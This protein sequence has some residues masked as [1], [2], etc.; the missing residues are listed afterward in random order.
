MENQKNRNS[1]EWLKKLAADESLWVPEAYEIMPAVIAHEYY[2]LHNLAEEGNVYGVILQ[3][4]DVYEAI[5]KY[6]CVLAL[7]ILQYAQTDENKAA[8][9]ALMAEVLKLKLSLGAWKG[10][11]DELKKNAGKLPPAL[12]EIIQ[13]TVKM[14]NQDFIDGSGIIQWRNDTIGHG[15]LRVENDS[16]LKK[17]IRLMVG[18]L[19][20][21][22]GEGG[23]DIA[24]GNRYDSI[25]LKQG[26]KNLVGRGAAKIE[27]NE[28]PFTLEIENR[29]GKKVQKPDSEGLNYILP[30]DG[31]IAFFDTYMQDK[32]KS[33]Y[34][35]YVDG[36]LKLELKGFFFDLYQELERKGMT[37]KAKG[38]SDKATDDQVEKLINELEKT[39][40]FEK[41]E[42]IY[43]W[44]NEKIESCAKGCFMLQMARGM[45]K[46]ALTS[47][48]DG[49]YNNKAEKKYIKGNVIVRTYHCSRNQLRG[50]NDFVMNI[51]SMFLEAD[52]L[53]NHIKDVEGIFKTVP[54]DSPSREAVTEML[55]SCAKELGKKI[56][57]VID[58][59]D[60]IVNHQLFSLFPRQEALAEGVYVFYTARPEHEVPSKALR[61]QIETI[62]LSE[63]AWQILDNNP[64]HQMVVRQYAKKELKNTYGMADDSKEYLTLADKADYNF[65]N[66]RILIPVYSNG[67]AID[68]ETAAD[69]IALFSNYLDFVRGKYGDKFFETRLLPLLAVFGIFPGGLVFKTELAVLL[70]DKVDNPLMLSATLNDL[71]GVLS[72][73]RSDRGNVYALA[74]EEY[75][76]YIRK[77]EPYASWIGKFKEECVAEIRAATKAVRTEYDQ[78]I[79]EISAVY[80]GQGNEQ[81]Y[82]I[83]MYIKKHFPKVFVLREKMLDLLNF[84]KTELRFDHDFSEED[85]KTIFFFMD[86]FPFFAYQGFRMDAGK[87]IEEGKQRP[88]SKELIA[89]GAKMDLSFAE[90]FWS[91]SACMGYTEQEYIRS[92]NVIYAYSKK[93]VTYMLASIKEDSIGDFGE[94]LFYISL[95]LIKTYFWS[96]DRYTEVFMQYGIMLLARNPI[97]DACKMLLTIIHAFKGVNFYKILGIY[98]EKIVEEDKVLTL[99]ECE[100]YLM[101]NEKFIKLIP[102]FDEWDI[103]VEES[104]II[105]DGDNINWDES[106]IKWQKS[107]L[108]SEGRKK[109]VAWKNNLLINYKIQSGADFASIKADYD[110]LIE[111]GGE[112]HYIE[113]EKNGRDERFFADAVQALRE[114]DEWKYLKTKLAEI[115]YS[116]SPAQL[117]KEL[118][119]KTPVAMDRLVEFCADK[120]REWKEYYEKAIEDELPVEYVPHNQIGPILAYMVV[121]YPDKSFRPEEGRYSIEFLDWVRKS[122]ELVEV[123][124][125]FP[126][127]KMEDEEIVRWYEEL[128][129]V[130]KYKIDLLFKYRE[131]TER[132]IVALLEWLAEMNVLNTKVYQRIYFHEFRACYHFLLSHDRERLYKMLD[133]NKLWTKIW[134]HYMGAPRDSSEVSSA[135]DFSTKCIVFS[136]RFAHENPSKA[137]DRKSAKTGD[138]Q[139]VRL[140][141]RYIEHYD[142]AP[143]WFAWIACHQ[144]L[145][146]IGQPAANAYSVFQNMSDL[147]DGQIKKLDADVHTDVVTPFNA[148]RESC[149]TCIVGALALNEINRVPFFVKRLRQMIDKVGELEKDKYLDRGIKDLLKDE[150]IFIK[151]GLE[152][153]HIIYSYLVGNE[154]ANNTAEEMRKAVN[155]ASSYGILFIDVSGAMGLAIL[156]LFLGLCKTLLPKDEFDEML[157]EKPVE[158][159]PVKLPAELKEDILG[160]ASEENVVMPDSNAQALQKQLQ[161]AMQTYPFSFHDGVFW[162]DYDCSIKE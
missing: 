75:V 144:L 143:D 111:V 20:E 50:V 125:S 109:Y 24:I 53:E 89:D 3:I 122:P 58:G 153:V 105:W 120:S 63:P 107:D 35:D 25:V 147:W 159:K 84:P 97:H 28:M 22:F 77:T 148:A 61:A 85:W 1:T 161:N 140:A 19:T 46:S 127:I 44:F 141:K 73:N 42:Y 88:W 16:S 78:W 139:A 74:N 39:Y 87:L 70:E 49:R 158:L 106:N 99:I 51:N 126:K 13:K 15:A 34:L 154:D 11:A 17:E 69:R 146:K 83:R 119:V 162:Y 6:P 160:G 116:P 129:S 57:L 90:D 108:N 101:C 142:D 152:L 68:K 2:Q 43:L 156:A 76:E 104:E 56:V 55:N 115:S 47:F 118:N 66:L 138:E 113:S 21:Y 33:K 38:F 45:G 71:K 133:K 36:H 48:I 96:W 8:Y 103:N 94:S 31:R 12:A 128:D 102:N 79:L 86:L 92:L 67:G 59:V 41:P 65:L 132:Q 100:K 81:A 98:M 82:P 7:S 95:R 112:P 10:I 134:E 136:A 135:L 64:D 52:N 14:F 91:L 150:V 145:R 80:R 32:E 4:K 30:F 151:K 137:S 72:V 124:G 18:K 149:Y 29:D 37:E 155:I 5:I 54:L 60:E 27:D 157:R 93:L 9:N 130:N 114:N 123:I 110:A 121:A 62:S 23:K 26:S 40:N 117:C 131:G